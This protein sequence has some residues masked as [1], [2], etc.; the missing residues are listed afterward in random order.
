MPRR[1]DLFPKSLNAT[2]GGDRPDF[3][4]VL[5]LSFSL[6]RNLV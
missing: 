4:A 2:P 5:Q 6:R 1:R 3:V